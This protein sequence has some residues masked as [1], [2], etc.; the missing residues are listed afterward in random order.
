MPVMFNSLY[1]ISKEHWN[2]YVHDC[3][4][5]REA[6]DT[7]GVSAMVEWSVAELC[8]YVLWC[9]HSPFPL[10]LPSP[11]TLTL[12]LSPPPLPLSTSSRTLTPLPSHSPPS[13]PLSPSSPPTLTLSP[14]TLTLLPSPSCPLRN[15]VTLVYNVLKTFMNMNGKMFDDLTNSYK[16]NRLRWVLTLPCWEC[17]QHNN[18]CG[19]A[20][21]S[22]WSVQSLNHWWF[23]IHCHAT[24]IHYCGWVHV[25]NGGVHSTFTACTHGA[26]VHPHWQLPT[27][28][29]DLPLQ[30]VE[31]SPV[32]NTH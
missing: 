23:C 27:A 5:W 11:P 6:E 7:L 4:L 29:Q 24:H 14:P 28:D 16:S 17:N 12:P 19:T 32:H 2:P 3:L 9:E 20:V 8:A 30:R 10:S 22:Y 25:L 21:D 13:F 26:A 31:G 18:L 1:R 15:I